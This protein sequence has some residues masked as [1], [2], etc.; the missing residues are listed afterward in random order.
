MSSDSSGPFVECRSRADVAGL[1]ARLV[2]PDEERAG[3]HLDVPDPGVGP[4][5]DRGESAWQMT[6]AQSK[7]APLP[8]HPGVDAARDLQPVHH[9]TGRAHQARS[10]EVAAAGDLERHRVEERPSPAVGR[11]VIVYVIAQVSVVAVVAIGVALWVRSKTAP[12]QLPQLGPIG[13]ASA[14]E[15]IHE[16]RSTPASHPKPDKGPRIHTSQVMA[17]EVQRCR[18]RA[19]AVSRVCASQPLG[20]ARIRSS[21]VDRWGRLRRNTLPL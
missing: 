5:G 7:P 17:P 12:A 18:D 3:L 4:A 21:S 6:F 9:A 14:E 2:D 1:H 8:L 11:E 16:A 10:H 19:E 13:V 15:P 20:I